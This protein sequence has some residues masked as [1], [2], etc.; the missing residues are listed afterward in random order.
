MGRVFDRKLNKHIQ[1]TAEQG[2]FEPTFRRL[3]GF[4]EDAKTG[5]ET[6]DASKKE[7]DIRDLSLQ[8]AAMVCFGSTW[9]EDVDPRNFKRWS[10]FHESQ[11]QEAGI[12]FVPPSQLLHI[13]TYSGLI[14]GLVDAAIWEGYNNPLL[15]GDEFVDVRETKYWQAGQKVIGAVNTGEVSRDLG[16]NEPYPYVGMDET[17]ITLP[18]QFR[19]GAMIAVVQQDV[20]GDLT[21]KVIEKANNAGFA[22]KRKRDLR[23]ADIVMGINNNSYIRDDQAYKTYQLT[24]DTTVGA[25]GR[26]NG[27]YINQLASNDLVDWTQLNAAE[28]LLTSQKDPAS[29]FSIPID[30]TK[31]VM[32]V[33][34]AKRAIAQLVANLTT[35]WQNRTPPAAGGD[36]YA[37]RIAQHSYPL[38][39][40]YRVVY[41]WEWY[42]R[43]LG[44]S[45][46]GPDY[47]PA[48][49]VNP[50]TDSASEG[51]AYW[52]VGQP[53]KA[54]RYNQYWPFGVEA[55]PL[56]EA[57]AQQDVV[58]ISRAREAGNC[59]V[60]E[61]R[62]MVECNG[63]VA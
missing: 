48:Y 3:L 29:G 30:M 27:N 37:D 52:W 35:V 22:I 21:G 23:I 7:I 20:I 28:I 40:N 17:W 16:D 54:F 4:V 51:Q 1:E 18:K 6:F 33:S 10:A 15:V 50:P 46:G 53:Q 14:G 56:S 58:H 63:T 49:L 24:A 25:K 60:V 36:E 59:S 13:S 43:L 62:F 44:T 41:S 38:A 47:D 55:V 39:A 9:K 19:N 8:E 26:S 11:L 2:T 34:P 31:L 32:L 45:T 5:R 12:P 42:R 57:A 61:P